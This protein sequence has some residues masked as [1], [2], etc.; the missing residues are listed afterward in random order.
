MTINGE[1]IDISDI[2]CL[3]LPPKG[4]P[5]VGFDIQLISGRKIHI[6]D[7]SD[8]LHLMYV[9]GKLTFDKN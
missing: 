4:L 1:E 9:H 7:D 6:L 5:H 2:V 3:F 8:L